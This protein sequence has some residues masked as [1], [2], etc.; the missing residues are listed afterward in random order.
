MVDYASK[1]D[2]AIFRAD[3]TH[4]IRKYDL[5]LLTVNFESMEGNGQS[6]MHG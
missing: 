6:V 5:V 4:E 3:L 2:D 1:S